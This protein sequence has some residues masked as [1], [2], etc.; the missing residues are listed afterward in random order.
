VQVEALR[1]SGVISLVGAAGNLAYLRHIYRRPTHSPLE[2]RSVFLL[3]VITALLL[4]RP[5]YWTI[6]G[7]L[8]HTLVLI[9]AALIPIASTLFVEMLRRRHAPPLV[10][11]IIA[12]GTLTAFAM[13]FI[14]WGAGPKEHFFD[15]FRWFVIGTFA[16]LA[17]S[18]LLRRRSDLS[19]ME[20]RFVDGT[21]AACAMGVIMAGT[22]FN[23]RP[24]WAP[25][26]LG[27][28]GSLFFVYCS[29]RLTNTV[30]RRSRLL[31]EIAR[32]LFE[33]ALIIAIFAAVVHGADRTV[34]AA[35]FALALAFNL[36][37]RVT[38]RL[39]GLHI[40]SGPGM[41]FFRWLLFSSATSLDD[42]VESMES[43]PWATKPLVLRGAEL[44]PYDAAAIAETF[45]DAHPIWTLSALRA[46]LRGASENVDGA[47]ELVDLLETRDMTHV[48]M[49]AR[50]PLVL[51]LV[52]LPEVA[53]P[54]EPALEFALLQKYSR[55]LHHE[56]AAHV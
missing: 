17:L 45:D 34:Y 30:E 50:A 21:M 31:M 22:D 29:V 53:G 9:P 16:W 52:N 24:S 5:I 40:K 18:L 23:V 26:Q 7:D 42:F 38:T 8:L 43:I 13:N 12:A 51:L 49:L 46:A 36:F 48:A 25:Y 35:G 15:F 33:S 55:L 2:G 41:S 56:D 3:S 1:L 20:N 19:P 10:K 6:G 44:E 14:F 32:I 39:R 37:I 27:G 11:W 4:L 54:H 28:I 47:E